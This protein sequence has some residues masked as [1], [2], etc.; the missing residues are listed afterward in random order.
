[1]KLLSTLLVSM[2]VLP[3]GHPV[4]IGNLSGLCVILSPNMATV[5]TKKGKRKKLEEETQQLK[6]NVGQNVERLRKQ[7]SLSQDALATLAGVSRA[8]LGQVESAESAP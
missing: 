1:M 6:R 8:M 2:E 3:A 4:N 5:S 7:R